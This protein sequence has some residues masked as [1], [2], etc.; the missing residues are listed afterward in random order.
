MA[1]LRRV[2]VGQWLLARP[3]SVYALLALVILLPLLKPGFVQ[4]LDMVFVP[5]W[6]LQEVS[7]SSYLF[8]AVLHFMDLILPSQL[9]Q[10]VM[11]FCILLFAGYGMH[12]F[13][14]L[15]KPQ[16]TEA[17]QWQIAQYAAGILY[18]LNPF[19]YSR[20]MAGQ[21]AVLLGYMALPIVARAAWLLCEK[22]SWRTSLWLAWWVAFVGIVS[23]H[24]LGLVVLLA[25]SIVGV[26]V[27]R[28]WGLRKRQLR[29]LK[30]L[31]ISATAVLI[32]SSYWLIPT[33]RGTGQTAQIVSQF[34]S[35]DERAFAT[36]SHGLGLVGNVLGLQGFWADDKNLYLMPQDVFRWWFVPILAMWAL[37]I[38][39]WWRWWRRQ[40]AQATAF[41]LLALL[42][43][44]LAIGTAGT[45]VAPVN[46]MLLHV[47]PFFSGYREPQKFVA[48]IA[49]VFAC[50]A[51]N[52]A[53]EL[54]RKMLNSKKWQEY[55]QPAMFATFA[56]IILCA[57][58]MPLGFRGQLHASSFP[59]GWYA[60]NDILRQQ[61]QK[62][63]QALYLPWHLYM[64]YDFAGRI[65]V[66]PAPQFFDATIVASPD[67]EYGQASAYQRTDTQKYIEDAALP[68]AKAGK[69]IAPGLLQHNIRYVIL[70]KEYDYQD[71]KYI[72]SQ[73]GLHLV[74]NTPSLILYEVT[75]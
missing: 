25:A 39:G 28:Q 50:F 53:L 30:W 55:A 2:S 24:T 3:W 52:G 63:C 65:I 13:M 58:L 75:E 29:L 40:A 14:T 66:N 41:A 34:N 31:A 73:A 12:R 57:P 48:L 26:F 4:T 23:V 61:C 47:V 9:I 36:I 59:Q 46:R 38:F 6:P 21:F 35:G 60:A 56:M 68:E 49:F 51:G 10:K 54:W 22:P 72:Q 19:V 70:A 27:W 16:D 74:L 69:P 64:R 45:F 33:L 11:L 67:P 5:H 15:L 32:A 42:S 1:G 37:V 43:A 18:M 7:R 44:A 71:Y 20:F 62:T 17:A 8:Y